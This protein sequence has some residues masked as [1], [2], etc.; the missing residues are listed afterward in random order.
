MHTKAVVAASL[1]GLA[2]VH[3][4]AGCPAE[5]QSVVAFSNQCASSAGVVGSTA[6]PSTWGGVSR[7][8]PGSGYGVA[9]GYG[10]APG[11]G[12]ASGYGAVPGYGAASGLSSWVPGLGGFNGFGGWGAGWKRD[13]NA[14]SVAVPANVFNAW[15]TT[16][17]LDCI[18]ANPDIYGSASKCISACSDAR[19]VLCKPHSIAMLIEAANVLVDSRMVTSNCGTANQAL[20]PN[21]AA[22]ASNGASWNT[23]RK[24]RRSAG[25][26][27]KKRQTAPDWS[28]S[29]SSWWGTGSGGTTGDTTGGTTGGTSSGTSGGTGGSGISGSAPS[30]APAT[31]PVIPAAVPAS[32]SL[33][34]PQGQGPNGNQLLFAGAPKL[35]H[36]LAYVVVAGLA[37]T[38]AIFL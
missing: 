25:P 8:N 26:A 15:S 37:T 27:L 4:Q 1:L 10:A 7:S 22:P 13:V 24:T 20:N 30:V 34:T 18:C 35:S 38:A 16:A 29:G 17:G 19:A 21:L 11:Y 9:S 36:G 14:N 6:S 32:G 5:C 28:G 12:A 2:G 33:P 31:S 3:A 23:G